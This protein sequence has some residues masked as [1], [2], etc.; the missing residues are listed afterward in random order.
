MF[1][2]QALL[3]RRELIEVK[4]GTLT[5]RNLE[6]SFIPVF[7]TV[8]AETPEMAFEIFAFAHPN[9]RTLLAVEPY[10]RAKHSPRASS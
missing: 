4:R 1:R 8:Y 3:Q 6:V 9:F 5:L 2:Y 7:G 10:D